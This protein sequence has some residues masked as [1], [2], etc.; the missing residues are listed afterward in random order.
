MTMYACVFCIHVHYI[1][2][3]KTIT[4]VLGLVLASQGPEDH[5]G[6]FEDREKYDQR[7]KEKIKG[8]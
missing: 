2:T 7:T 1:L 5:H 8:A 6:G 4:K 3:I